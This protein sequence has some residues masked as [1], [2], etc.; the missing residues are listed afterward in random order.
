MRF[1]RFTSCASAPSTKKKIDSNIYYGV[2]T[3]RQK[4]AKP[5]TTCSER[6]RNERTERVAPSPYF[7]STD[8]TTILVVVISTF[9]ISLEQLYTIAAILSM[10]SPRRL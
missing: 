5:V 6:C 1:P 10:A 7:I 3:N 4:R 9:A 8:V 2:L